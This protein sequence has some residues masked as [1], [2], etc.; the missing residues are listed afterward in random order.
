MSES[1][2]ES[3]V[4]AA[5]SHG[6]RLDEIVIGFYGGEPL[7]AWGSLVTAVRTAQKHCGS[8]R[9][10]FSLT[11]NGT[12]LD[13]P[14]CRFLSDCG[15]HVL[16]SLDGPSALH[17]RHR[18]FPDG[19]G[20]YTETLRG[21]KCL[22]DAYPLE[23]HSLIAL[24]MVV[25]GPEWFTEL[26]RLWEDEP[27]IPATLQA[28]ANVVTPP[29]GYKY[30]VAPAGCHAELLEQ[31][32]LARLENGA[33]AQTTLS[34]SQ[35]DVPLARLHQRSIFRDRQGFFP[36][37]CCVPGLRRIYVETDGTYRLCERVHGLPKL[38]NVTE[39]LDF[40]AIQQLVHDFCVKSLA[41]CQSCWAV[42]LC[43]LCY[44]DAYECGVFNLEKKRRACEG[45]RNALQRELQLY[46]LTSLHHPSTLEE[47]TRFQI[48]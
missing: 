14:K 43:R 15:A 44:G 10:R 36:N 48:R 33:Q 4:L 41:D 19:R 46:C 31:R 23:N 2:I 22:L 25:P 30:P 26:E 1:V 37:G 32:W 13:D 29:G 12:L 47:W 8:K 27:W 38:G 20:S 9:V 17:D 7:S 45:M 39:G 34:C 28:Q 16:V 42:S 35:I 40:E 21:L 18:V 6:D 11:T 24:N 5:L 3:A